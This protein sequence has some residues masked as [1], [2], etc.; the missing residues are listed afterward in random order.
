MAGFVEEGSVDDEEDV[1]CG[2]ADGGD[3]AF[4]VPHCVVFCNVNFIF[5]LGIL[6]LV[7]KASSYEGPRLSNLFLSLLFCSSFF[8]SSSCQMIVGTIEKIIYLSYFSSYD[9]STFFPL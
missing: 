5:E 3:D 9:T 1:A 4:E 8:S 6:F 2:E 7:Q